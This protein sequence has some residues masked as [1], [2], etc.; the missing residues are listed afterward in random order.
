VRPIANYQGYWRA[1]GDQLKGWPTRPKSNFFAGDVDET[2]VYRTQLTS[3]R[4]AAHFR[5][6]GR[7]L[8]L[9]DDDPTSSRSPSP[10]LPSR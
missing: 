4:V 9:P 3:Q 5:A 2:A 7:T 6:S 10:R 8:D 1:G